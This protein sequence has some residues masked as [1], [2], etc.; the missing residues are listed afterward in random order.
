MSN[1]LLI[2]IG[3]AV[4]LLLVGIMGAGFYVILNKIS[5]VNAPEQEIVEEVKEEEETIKEMFPLQS[6]VVNLADKNGKRY[7]RSSIELEMSDP[8]LKEEIEQR[9]PKVRD[10]ILMVLPLK[11]SADLKS[12]EGKVALRDEIMEK[13]NSFL[14]K[15]TITNVYFTEFVIQ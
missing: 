11:S 5:A 4:V 7:L 15:G 9:L 13:I 8:N 6:F 3:A 2:I 10:T 12:H 14:T 1:K